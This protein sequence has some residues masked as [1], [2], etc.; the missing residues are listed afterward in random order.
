M[1]APNPTSFFDDKI[2]EEYTPK[3]VK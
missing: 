2:E 3:P 1:A